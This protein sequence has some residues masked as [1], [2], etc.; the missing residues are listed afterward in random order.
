MAQM[1]VSDQEAERT[2]RA[3]LPANRRAGGSVSLMRRARRFFYHRVM[4][5]LTLVHQLVVFLGKRIGPRPHLPADGEGLEVLLTG[6]FFSSDWPVAFLRPL[7]ASRHCSRVVVVSSYPVPDIDKVMTIYPPPWLT[8]IVGSTPARLLVFALTAFRRRPH[9][10]GGFHMKV[11]ALAATALAPWVGA[12]ALYFCVGGPTEVL[13]GGIWGEAKLFERMETP[14]ALVERR[15]VKAADACDVI[16][17]MGTGA[18]EFFRKK[19]VAVP[20]HVVPGG[21][22]KERFSPA[23]EVAAIDLVLVGRL[24]EVKSIDLFLHAV[25]CVADVMPNIKA[26]VVGEGPLRGDLEQLARNLGIDHCVK[27]TGFEP[28]VSDW[29]RQARIF[30]LTSHSEG[31]SLALMEA[32]MCGLPAVVAQVG[33]LGDLVQDDV[34]GYLVSERCA[35][36]FAAPVL[37]LLAD[38][39]K[40]AAF[41]QAA[42]R[43][44]MRYEMAEVTLMWDGILAM[45]SGGGSRAASG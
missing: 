7:A 38:D 31:L 25:R 21:M 10:V 8:R 16:I 15:L 5:F 17:T 28:R 45:L 9:I 14:D 1:S 29:L 37:G 22:D 40:Y 32:M 33:D 3:D 13:D 18:A 26:V 35:E 24:V 23:E 6:R 42:R 19:G 20:I 36:A 30:M 41:S 4:R 2:V 39:R 43:M 11:N 12:R 44:A 27:F 34:N